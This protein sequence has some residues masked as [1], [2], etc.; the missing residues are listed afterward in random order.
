MDAEALVRPV[1]ETAGFELIEVSFH[2]EGRGRPVLRVTVDRDA[3]VDLDAIAQVSTLIARRLDEDD[4]GRDRYELE[5]SSPGIER[6]LK[7][8]AQFR[9]AVGQTVKVRTTDEVAGSNVHAG[10]LVQV[11]D[12][13]ITV[14]ED[15]TPVP[16]PLATVASARTV[17]D[18]AA[19]LKGS[20]R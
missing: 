14:D 20:A 18:W 9:R 7:T 5:V 13:T 17:A 8:I 19:E 12:E 4:F 11:D 6:P 2:G 3:G 16:I 10:A 15:G 1:V